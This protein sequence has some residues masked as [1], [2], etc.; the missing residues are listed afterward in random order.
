MLLSANLDC[1]LSLSLSLL[2]AS[3]TDHRVLLS[4]V[5]SEC[6]SVTAVVRKLLSYPQLAVLV[7][8]L[9]ILMMDFFAALPF[10]HLIWSDRSL[11]CL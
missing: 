1:H 8:I 10:S 9:M 11:L 6:P 5:L 3:T 7:M 4:E 2:L